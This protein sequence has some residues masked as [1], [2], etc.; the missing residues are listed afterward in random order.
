M[1]QPS[2]ESALS[3]LDGLRTRRRA[4]AMSTRRSSSIACSAWS[5]LARKR[6]PRESWRGSS[7]QPAVPSVDRSATPRALDLQRDAQAAAAGGRAIRIPGGQGRLRLQ[8]LRRRGTWLCAGPRRARRS[9]CRSAGEQ[10]ATVRH[11]H[12]GGRVSRAECQSGGTAGARGPALPQAPVVPELWPP[13]PL[14]RARRRSTARVTRTWCRRSR[15]NQQ[16]P[17]FRG[18]IREP[19]TGVIEVLIDARGGV[20]SASMIASIN[21]QY[22]R[23]GRSA[24]SEVVDV[25]ARARRWCAGQ[26]RQA[27]PGQSRSRRQLKVAATFVSRQTERKSL[28]SCFFPA[29]NLNSS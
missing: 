24:C 23:H 19:Q 1:R 20:E 17:S 9:R 4:R 10:V 11:S 29:S 14:M 2:T 21:P 12:A 26:I 18:Q 7:P 28:R 6:M 27:N 15:L 8:G 25:P 22:D 3:M 5:R 16:I 13:R